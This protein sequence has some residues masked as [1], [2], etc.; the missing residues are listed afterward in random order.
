MSQQQTFV[1]GEVFTDKVKYST[2]YTVFTAVKAMLQGL[3]MHV[4]LSCCTTKTY[5]KV[6][7]ALQKG[8]LHPNLNKPENKSH[9]K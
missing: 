3:F 2:V 8:M 9:K 7:K 1:S 4:D 6:H 5:T